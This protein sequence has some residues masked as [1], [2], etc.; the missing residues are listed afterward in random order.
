MKRP[1]TAHLASRKSRVQGLPAKFIKHLKWRILGRLRNVL[2]RGVPSPMRIFAMNFLQY[3]IPAQD[4]DLIVPYRNR[5]MRVR[6]DEHIGRMLLYGAY[7]PKMEWVL[8]EFARARFRH[9]KVINCLDVGAN[10]GNC[11]LL[12]AGLYGEATGRII[13]L[14]PHLESYELLCENVELNSL[15][16]LIEPRCVGL[17]EAPGVRRFRSAEAG[18]NRSNS[19]LASGRELDDLGTADQTTISCVN[20]LSLVPEEGLDLILADLEKIPQKPIISISV[21]PSV[22]LS[23]A[24]SA[25]LVLTEMARLGYLLFAVVP[26]FGD[27]VLA[28]VEPNEDALWQEYGR[29]QAELEI[30]ALPGLR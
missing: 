6:G 14:E 20:L 17:A 25:F 30:I 18:V 19:Q 11:S 13:A 27:F 28:R 4:S 2:G 26:D 3:A 24:E 10:V 15:S 29:E 7:R 12:L 23:G 9:K 21:N 22:Q 8:A 16:H 5:F 1:V